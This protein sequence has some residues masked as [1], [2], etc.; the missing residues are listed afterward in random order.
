MSD[1][2]PLLAASKPQQEEAIYPPVL[3]APL[4]LRDP[5]VLDTDEVNC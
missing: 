3:K 4:V 1:F 2:T 5:L